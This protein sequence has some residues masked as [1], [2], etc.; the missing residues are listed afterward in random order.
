M[1]TVVFK[2]LLVI[3]CI[4]LLTACTTVD[5]HKQNDPTQK[6]S[7]MNFQ[8]SIVGDLPYNASQEYALYNIISPE[9]LDSD[10]II[11]V[12]DYKAGSNQ[13]C[14]VDLDQKH[15]TWMIKLGIPV[16]YSPGDNDWAD[17]DRASNAPVVR[18]TKRLK[19][20]RATFF[21]PVPTPIP[22]KWNAT[23]QVGAPENSSWFVNGIRFATV[24]VIG[25]NNGRDTIGPCAPGTVC[26]TRS[27]IAELVAAREKQ[28]FAWIKSTFDKAA[29][30][31]AD[32]VVLALHADMFQGKY[33]DIECINAAQVECDGF[34][35]LRET[36]IDKSSEFAK[37]VLLVHGDTGAYCWDRTMGGTKAPNLVRLNSAG[38]Y[39]LIDAVDVVFDPDSPKPF[40]AVGTISNLLPAETQCSRD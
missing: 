23:W 34:K 3:G 29:S 31:D 28:S 38:D 2:F 26:D 27:D 39:V 10:F 7:G 35:T 22:A 8:F 33:F 32:A 40:H 11:H 19:E 18:E 1:A 37:P 24:H 14:T 13:P 16:F 4:G 9:V 36:I 20:I 12:G 17:C 25:G 5:A 6:R 30:E 15:K 21:D